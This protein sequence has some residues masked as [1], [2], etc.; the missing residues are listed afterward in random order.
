[1]SDQSHNTELMLVLEAGAGAADR[2]QAVLAAVRVA[3]VVVVP[4]GQRNLTAADLLPLVEIGQRYGAAVLVAD[5]PQLARTVK[6]D[7]V[8]LSVSDTLEPRL[9][10]A[11]S[12]VGGRAVLGADAGRSRD[13][14]MT[15]GE[16]GADYVAFGIP[17]FV[18]DREAAYE[19]QVGLVAWWAEIFEI[20][21]VAMDVA[22]PEHAAALFEAGADFVALRL[23][24][25]LSLV[26]A[27]SLAR[28]WASAVGQGVGTDVAREG[29]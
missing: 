4:A 15:I 25:G 14:A 1:M 24:D 19:R 5:D 20:P 22:G 26:E 2:L 16:F 17:D 10:D 11:R 23:G 6:A 18:K 3:C 29:S 8:H 13:D 7:G 9:E 21:C 27:L 28:Q 12:V